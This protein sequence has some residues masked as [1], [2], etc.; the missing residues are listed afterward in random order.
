VADNWRDIL[1]KDLDEM[2]NKV[3]TPSVAL[4]E[5]RCGS[6]QFVKEITGTRVAVL[7]HLAP[8]AILLDVIR[9]DVSVGMMK[10]KTVT[11]EDAIEG[12]E[13]WLSLSAVV[14]VAVMPKETP[15]VQTPPSG[16]ILT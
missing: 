1:D 14:S 6:S 4:E 12:R 7:C 10:V 8:K 13:W 11:L 16:I 3:N 9:V 15:L 5:K 2:Q